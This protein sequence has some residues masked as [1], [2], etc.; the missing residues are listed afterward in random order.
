LAASSTTVIPHF[1]ADPLEAPPRR[2]SA[3]LAVDAPLRRAL[4]LAS[5]VIGQL[6]YTRPANRRRSA[7]RLRRIGAVQPPHFHPAVSRL[8]S[9]LL[10]TPTL[11]QPR[12][13]FPGFV[14]MAARCAIMNKQCN[15][16]LLA[17]SRHRTSSRLLN[18]WAFGGLRTEASIEGF[19]ERVVGWL[20][21]PR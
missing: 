10:R 13:A 2:V 19:Y 3:C 21:W 6:R 17:R 16:G 12:L 9:A 7:L 11:D 1:L 18:L 15:R 14:M 8:R 5:E 4:R 20:A